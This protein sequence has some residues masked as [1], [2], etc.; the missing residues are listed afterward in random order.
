MLVVKDVKRYSARVFLLLEILIFLFI[1]LFGKHGLPLLR[2][3]EDQTAQLQKKIT[4]LK[5]DIST[6]KFELDQWDTDPFYKEKIAREQLQMA[7]AQE[8]IYYLNT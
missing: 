2:N 1:F 5:E 4:F 3:L 7:Y 8:E 6:L